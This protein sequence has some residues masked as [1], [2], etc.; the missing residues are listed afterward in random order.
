M[1]IANSVVGE[2]GYRTWQEAIEQVEIEIGTQVFYAPR[3]VVGV[4]HQVEFGVGIAQTQAA[5]N[6][7]HGAVGNAHDALLVDVRGQALMAEFER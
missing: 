1:V 7:R 6:G 3:T 4:Q 2:V 5:R